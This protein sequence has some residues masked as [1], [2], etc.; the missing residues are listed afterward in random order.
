[1]QEDTTDFGFKRVPYQQKTKLVERVFNSVAGKY[2]LMNDLMSFGIHRL[3]KKLAISYCTPLAGQKILDLAGGTGDLAA[4]LLAATN[5]QAKVLLA[6]I[7]HEMLSVGRHKL[8]NRGFCKGLNYLQ[9]NAECLPFPTNSFDTII[10]GFGLRN[11][12]DKNAALHEMQRV[13]KPSGRVVILEFS[14]PV[15]R[16]LRSVYDAY[17]FQALPRLGKLITGDQESYQYLAESIQRHPPQQ[18]LLSMLQN[19][20]FARCSYDNLTGGICA[21]HRGFKV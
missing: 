18:E 12:T 16:W 14:Q 8:L 7:N 19:A 5:H 3:W 4:A 13:L 6:D 21:I 15:Y 10:I 20:G 9:L 11:V 2:D 1:M 17:S